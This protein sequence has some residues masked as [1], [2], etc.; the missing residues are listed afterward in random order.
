MFSTT[1]EPNVRNPPP[2]TRYDH[3]VYGLSG[4]LFTDIGFTPVF[5]PA[6]LNGW[7]LND[8]GYT[9]LW[10]KNDGA[11]ATTCTLSDNALSRS[12]SIPIEVQVTIA[13]GEERII[14]PCPDRDLDTPQKYVGVDQ[15]LWGRVD[16][17]RIRFSNTSSV[18][19]ACIRSNVGLQRIRSAP[20]AANPPWVP[21]DLPGTELIA[22]RAPLDHG[23]VPVWHAVAAAGNNI[24]NADGGA[25]RFHPLMFIFKNAA[26]ADI[27]VTA[28]NRIVTS[29]V[30]YN[31]PGAPYVWIVPAGET[32]ITDLAGSGWFS[33]TGVHLDYSSTGGLTAAIV[34]NLAYIEP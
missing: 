16:F 24:L 23:I 19:V 30:T 15:R 9:M 28:R 3:H 7:A 33:G 29:T 17:L 27:T 21:P 8:S 25:H 6:Q 34:Q 11:A 20:L 13:A 10:V 32:L 4:R 31:A 1:P 18:S 2:G 12:V 22:Q 14:G 5:V 26:G